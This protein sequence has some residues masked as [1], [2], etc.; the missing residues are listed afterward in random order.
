MR[1]LHLHSKSP[2][3]ASI[4]DPSINQSIRA[5]PPADSPASDQPR[6]ATELL[7]SELRSG[8]IGLPLAEMFAGYFSGSLTVQTVQGLG[9]DSLL[10]IPRIML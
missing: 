6:V 5:V 7:D 1:R 8:M 3:T 9:S 4:L 2:A 10:T